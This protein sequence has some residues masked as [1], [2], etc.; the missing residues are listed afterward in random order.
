MDDINPGGSKAV[1]Y[2][3]LPLVMGRA[4][5]RHPEVMQP[6]Y[7]LLI[8]HQ[9]SRCKDTRDRV[10]S[11]LGLI[12]EDE[13]SLL[14][15]FFPDYTLSDDHI[16]II[17]LAYLTQC[18]SILSPRGFPRITAGSE[19]LFLGLGVKSEART[20]YLIDRTEQLDYLGAE[21][22]GLFRQLAD[23][24]IEQELRNPDAVEL[25][26]DGS[27][28]HQSWESGPDGS[29][30]GVARRTES[31]LIRGLEAPAA[32]IPASRAEAKIAPGRDDPVAGDDPR[33]CCARGL[34][35]KR[36]L[37]HEKWLST[38]PAKYQSSIRPAW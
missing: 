8:S 3:A 12:L 5:D 37:Q 6:L 2:S 22:V 25:A 7:D 15:R 34:H 23:Q 29:R 17:T 33:E 10:F 26:D 31:Y 32:Q 19:E 28:D 9:R 20:R 24:D 4:L 13:R 27:E 16:A 36:E 14:R 38:L 1:T 21:W 18:S 35:H 30:P 11:L